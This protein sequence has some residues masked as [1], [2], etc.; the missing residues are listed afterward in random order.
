VAGNLLLHVTRGLLFLVA[1]VFLKLDV[2][3]A[4]WAEFVTWL[5]VGGY[6]AR[7]MLRGTGM[8]FRMD[9]PLARDQV[10][11]GFQ[12]HLGNIAQRMNLQMS[13]LI[14]SSLAGAGAVGLFSVAVNMA[15]VLW[16]IP[17]SVGRIL[18]P[19][20]ASSS[21]EDANRVTALACRNTILLTLVASLA[22]F[23]LGRRIILL[24]YTESFIDSV[25]PLFLLLPGIVAL[26]ISKVL[27]KY[28]SGIG[29]PYYNSTASI[30][31]FVANVPIMYLLVR[32]HGVGGAAAATSIVY[33]LHAIMVT[34]FYLRE[35]GTP[36]GSTLIPVASDLQ[37]YVDG[38]Q[39]M[40]RRLR[41]GKMAS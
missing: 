21:R 18:F 13:T 9:W 8:D 23:L 31:A 3:G 6:Y 16:Y 4:V 12:A 27:T 40:W 28:L 32:S 24:L 22:L 1:L 29:K 33:G 2:R 25:R 38:V 34:A 30:L 7:A 36:P 14:L 11:Y 10:R 19:R 26:S 20:V 5:L 37:L 35:S 39:Q 17:D 15:Q 41:W